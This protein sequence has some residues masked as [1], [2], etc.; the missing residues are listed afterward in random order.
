MK[1]TG[2][3]CKIKLEIV[4]CAIMIGME[5]LL[6]KEAVNAKCLHRFKER[7]DK[8]MYRRGPLWMSQYRRLLRVLTSPV[9][10]PLFSGI[11]L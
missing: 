3:W 11:Y 4:V 10:S 1:L 2:T 8:C 6:P 9:L 7:Q 5:H